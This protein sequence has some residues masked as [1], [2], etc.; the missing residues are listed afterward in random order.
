MLRLMHEHVSGDQGLKSMGMFNQRDDCLYE[1]PAFAMGNNGGNKGSP[2][3]G[4]HVGSPPNNAHLDDVD[5]G[6]S[7]SYEEDKAGP[8]VVIL[9][10]ELESWHTQLQDRV[11]IR[12]CHG[13]RPSLESLCVWISQNWESKNIMITHVQ[14]L[15]NGYYL[16][17]CSDAH[18]ALQIVGQGQWLIRSTPILVFNWFIGFNPKGP[19]PTKAPVWV[20]FIDF[21]IELYPWLKPI[22][23]SLGGVLGQRSRRG[24][25]PKFDPQLLIEIDLSKELKYLIPIKDSCGRALH[26]QKVVYKTLPNAYFNCMKMEHFI[27]DCPDLKPQQAVPNPE[28]KEDFEPVGKRNAI[29]NFKNNKASSSKNRNRFSPLLEDVFDP[30]ENVTNA[31]VQEN[32]SKEVPS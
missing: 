25:K 3:G 31:E 32:S 15:P 23:N 19:K 12:L 28:K 11:V 2:L 13:V 10:K 14:Y 17:F 6:H 26:N 18:S 27:K 30:L 29:I 5:K 21:P 1:N 16:I 9:A 4:S 20:D 22:G 7:V 8:S 24:I